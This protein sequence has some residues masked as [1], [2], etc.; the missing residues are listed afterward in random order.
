M[1]ILKRAVMVNVLVLVLGLAVTSDLDAQEGLPP[2][3]DAQL[4]AIAENPDDAL[5]VVLLQTLVQANPQFAVPIAVRASRIRPALAPIIASVT[6]AA[7]PD[8]APAIA[9][10]VAQAVP[11][12]A[13]NIASAVVQA[14]PQSATDTF[15]AVANV[16]P[17]AASDVA[18]A[19]TRVAP[20]AATTIG[21]Q[22]AAIQPAAG[23]PTP[24]PPPIGTLVREIV[25]ETIENPNVVSPTTP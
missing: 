20:E 10:G 22:L 14:V 8:E 16:V 23:A 5:V 4:T 17:E 1:L 13:A 21:T 9:A 15:A 3:L 11:D 7:A 18:T 25:S 6:T 19:V 24:P 12:E 2:E